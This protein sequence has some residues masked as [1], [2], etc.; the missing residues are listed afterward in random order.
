MPRFLFLLNILM[1][2]SILVLNQN[3]CYFHTKVSDITPI[4]AAYFLPD[5]EIS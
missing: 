2:R 4:W 5:T 3:F 1:A